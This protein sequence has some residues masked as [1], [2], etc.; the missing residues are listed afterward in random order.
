M[1]QTPITGVKSDSLL[2][3]GSWQVDVAVDSVG[4]EG[5][6][7]SGPRLWSLSPHA[8]P[9]EVGMTAWS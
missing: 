1:A 6:W 2:G 7:T 9:C 5:V 8:H 4:L 3:G